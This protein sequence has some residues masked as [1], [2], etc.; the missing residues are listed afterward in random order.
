MTTARPNPGPTPFFGRHQSMI[1]DRSSAIGSE[2][3]AATAAR[4]WLRRPRAGRW[5]GR[6][7]TILSVTWR[8]LFSLPTYLYRLHL[9]WLFGR[10]FL[11]LVHTGRRTGQR[12]HTVLEVMAYRPAERE[13]VVM[14]GFGPKAGWLLNIQATP[15]PRVVIGSRRFIAAF[16]ILPEAEAVQ[17]IADYERR[18]RFAAPIIRF[19]LSRLVGWRDDGSARSRRRVAA[20]RPMVAFR[21]RD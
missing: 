19:V 5:Q 10:R 8:R 18:H 12:R 9:G 7:E 21:P 20:S 16:R 17:V 14:S 4:S 1:G 2:S 15:N 3:A 6:H 11:M 13:A